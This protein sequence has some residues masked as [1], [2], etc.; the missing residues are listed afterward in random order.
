MNAFVM[1]CIFHSCIDFCKFPNKSLF[2]KI[3]TTMKSQSISR[4][5]ISVKDSSLNGEK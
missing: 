2:L 3:V 1:L 5:V 4:K